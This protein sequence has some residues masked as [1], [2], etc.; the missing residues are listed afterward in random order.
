MLGVLRLARAPCHLLQPAAVD[1]VKAHMTSRV[2][3]SLRGRQRYFS[4]SPSWFHGWLLIP[5]VLFSLA[6]AFWLTCLSA[7]PSDVHAAA[8]PTPVPAPGSVKHP[9]DVRYQVRGYFHAGGRSEGLGGFAKSDNVPRPA[10]QS[11]GR[12]TLQAL[13]TRLVKF[14]Q[15][16]GY[17]VLLING[18]ADEFMLRA[19]DS[20]LP[21][22]H[23]ARDAEGQW[24]AIE[25]LPGSWCGNS[26]HELFLP[27]RHYWQFEAPHYTGTFPTQLRLRLDTPGGPIYSNEFAGRINPEQLVAENKQGHEPASLMDPYDD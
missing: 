20:R 15:Y 18:T 14:N 6:G 5:L 23:E 3:R 22:V 16:D 11:S 4:Q 12:V 19:Q 7:L 8:A 24:Q 17:R 10:K 26:Y 9:V 27:S 25:Y 2:L 21:L 1:V 13:P